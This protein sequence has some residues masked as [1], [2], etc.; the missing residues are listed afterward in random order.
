M[1][2]KL[3]AASVAVALSQQ[4]V[5]ATYQLTELPRYEN[6]KHTII[7]DANEAGEVIGQASSLFGV[8]IDVSY[9]DFDDSTLTSFY[10]DEERR[11]KKIDEEITFT[12]DDIKNND[13]ANTNA[14][15]H[16]FMLSYISSAS[17]SQ[18]T[19]YQK[20]ERSLSVTFNNNS[21]EEFVVFDEQSPDYDGLTRSVENYLTGITDDGTIVGWGSAPY[22]KITFTPEGETEEETYFVRDWRKK[23]VMVTP[24]GEKIR[25]E[26]AFTEYGGFS[27]AVDIKKT[28][29]GGYVVVGQSS[30]ALS[31]RAIET[32]EDNCDGVDEPVEVCTQSVTAPFHTRA[33]KWTFDN[34][35]N[36]IDTIDLGLAFTP[37][38]DDELAYSSMATATN[39]SGL[40]VG[41][42]RARRQS[43]DERLPYEQA[44]YFKD[45]EIKR[46]KEVESYYEYSKAVDVNDNG[47]IVGV[48]GRLTGSSRDTNSTGF[49]FDTNTSE[50]KEIPGY[51][52]N[53]ITKVG[54]INNNGVV[55]GHGVATKSDSIFD[56]EAFIYEIGAEKVVNINSLLPCRGDDFPYTVAE[57]V[58]IT[59]DNKIY[60]IARKTVE[61]RNTLGGIEKDSSGEIEYESVTLPVLL[62]PI[63]GEPESC[64]PPEAETYERQ[65]ASW[66]WLTLL[67]LPLVALRRR[68]NTN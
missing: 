37:D 64:T 55:V 15:A 66:S 54:D 29:D 16:V 4:A 63:A 10:E 6:G 34:D 3:L 36:L 45:G 17:R 58:K 23:G 22:Q 20:V 5:A 35:F 57:A 49:Y 52:D 61:R 56:R 21:A 19:Q 33:Y 53:S 48:F 32:I 44:V 62:T 60:A 14:Q 39:A 24:A 25:L 2:F 47:I 18:S 7:L 28:I 41:F 38:E 27:I 9:I 31:D 30:T 68:R 8:K 13:A 1:K 65:S 12:L 51:Y 43:D 50:F 40:A 59:D 46:I 67:A 11:L 26:P 42:S